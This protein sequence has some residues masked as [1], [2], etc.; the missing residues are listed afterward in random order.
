MEFKSLAAL[1]LE[2]II[3]CF[4]ASFAGYSVKMPEDVEY[5]RDR[6]KAAR[7]DY[8]LCFGA[9]AEGQ[10]VGF[11][12]NGIDHFQGKKTA[13]NTGTGVV[14]KYRGNQLV[15]KIYDYAI[16]ILKEYKVSHL[17]LHVIDDNDRAI[18][19]YERIGFNNLK[20]VYNY[21]ISL[22][23]EKDATPLRT[24]SF[25]EIEKLDNPFHDTYPWD[26]TKEAMKIARQVYNSY[27]LENEDNQVI[28]FACINPK[29][30]FIAQLE[31]YDLTHLNLLLKGLSQKYTNVRIGNV[32][33]GRQEYRAELKR[34]GFKNT[35]NQFEMHRSI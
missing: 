4:L 12:I 29:S 16:P 18:R 15:D 10:L 14:P 22:V 8:N 32:D 34:L 35:I 30:G 11:I 23:K 33:G 31:T 5:W 25:D 6:F 17:A 13:F 19:V 26:S 9:F 24:S 21:S 3:D 1:S 7:V 2:E 27:I 20:K 28:G